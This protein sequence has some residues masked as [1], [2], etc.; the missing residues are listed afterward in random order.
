[1]ARICFVNHD[2]YPVLNADYG[3]NYIGGESVQQVLIARALAR[4]GHEVS[5]LV[6]DL[7]QPD[8]EVIDGITVWKTFKP[9][10]GLPVL[11][12]LHPKLTSIL[13]ALR[14]ADADIYYQS[15]AGMTTGVVAWHARRNN[16]K[17]VFRVAHDSDCVRGQQLIKYARDRRLYEYGLAR[18]DIIAAQSTKQATLLEQNYG[19]GSVEVPMAVEPPSDQQTTRDIDVLWVNNLRAFKR[20]EVFLELA[21]ALPELRMV[22]IG[23]PCPGDEPYYESIRRDAAALPNLTMTGFVPYHKVNDYYSRARIFVNTSDI[24]GFPNSYLQAWIRGTPVV[25]FFDPDGLI[26][27]R[28][29]GLRV[30]SLEEM[31]AAVTRLVNDAGSWGVLSAGSR[32]YAMAEHHPERIAERYE[33]LFESRLGIK[34]P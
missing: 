30:G 26:E 20:P 21:A 25:A 9:N 22:M 18:A 6:A 32:A 19:L 29:L 12:F 3:G 1:M 28:N 7:G 11:R 31:A 33:R 17:F 8:G 10:S 5:T 24:E 34:E 13:A 15:C 23:G 14:R 2:N 27:R 16:R 4:R